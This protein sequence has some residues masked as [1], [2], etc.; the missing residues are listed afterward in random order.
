MDSSLAAGQ[1]AKLSLDGA[2]SRPL[3]RPKP[4][5]KEGEPKERAGA[6]PREVRPLALLSKP[7]AIDNAAT[8][9]PLRGAQAAAKPKPRARPR[10][11]AGETLDAAGGGEAAGGTAGRAG[12]GGAA[13]RVG[14]DAGADD[15]SDVRDAQLK[16]LLVRQAEHMPR[17]LR[18]L[19]QHGRKTSHWAWWAF[20]TEKEGFSEPEPKTAVTP[21]S[22]RVVLAR[23]PGAWREVLEE[24]CRLT[25][26]HG[27]EVLPSIDHGRVDFFCR[28]WPTVD[29]A[30]E[31]LHSVC[32]TLAAAYGTDSGRAPRSRLPKVGVGRLRSI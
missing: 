19:K 9:P 32:E 1:L 18:E 20:P 5:P 28:F 12:G 17:A 10:P 2:K 13:G 27:S 7:K 24:V 16:V 21:A 29:G 26:T 14:G 4:K 23:A 3:A 30:P 6:D 11:T 15:Y 22:A 25:A 31:W 8:G